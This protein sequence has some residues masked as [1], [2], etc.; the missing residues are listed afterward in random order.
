[1]K[2]NLALAIAFAVTAKKPTAAAARDAAA[3]AT[4]AV[5]GAVGAI[6]GI[7]RTS[8]VITSG[9]SLSEE[10]QYNNG[11]RD[12]KPVGYQFSQQIRVSVPNLTNDLLAAVIDAAV[13][14]GGDSLS[15]NSV[16]A[17]FTPDLKQKARARWRGAAAGPSLSR[18]R[19]RTAGRPAAPR[20]AACPPRTAWGGIMR[21]PLSAVPRRVSPDPPRRVSPDPPRRVPPPPPLLPTPLQF[22]SQAQDQ[23]VKNAQATAN[24]LAK[25][26][27]VPLGTLTCMSSVNTFPMPWPY[28][29][30][31]SGERVSRARGDAAVP[32]AA[33]A[34]ARTPINV[35]TSTVTATVTVTYLIGNGTT[36]GRR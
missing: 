22:L 28:M 8:G 29:T 32:G 27:G 34:S 14:A 9:I 15:I 19:A 1:M 4:A 7:D 33:G 11:L 23:A 31:S 13:T 5:I 30:A 21:L 25:S 16:S 18:A 2:C 24:V 26:A 17:D 3:N 35:G 20:G 12:T 6:N 10:W 36:A